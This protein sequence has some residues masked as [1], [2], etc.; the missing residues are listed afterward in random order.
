LSNFGSNLLFES[1]SREKPDDIFYIFS[2]FI[3]DNALEPS[4]KHAP[5]WETELP[6][7]QDYLLSTVYGMLPML[8]FKFPTDRDVTAEDVELFKQNQQ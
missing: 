5:R 1:V 3:R 8:T 2:D 4:N 7:I 6:R